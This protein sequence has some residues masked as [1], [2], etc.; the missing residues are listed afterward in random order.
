M[1][2]LLTDDEVVAISVRNGVAWPS[3]LPTIELSEDGLSRSERSGLR[4]LA[5]RGFLDVSQDSPTID[6]EVA[7][8]VL[9]A[10]KA[11][12]W[13]AAYVAA[14]DAPTVLAGDS[15]Y[16]YEAESESLLDAVS[17]AGVHQFTSTSADDARALFVALAKNVFTFGVRGD[18]TDA[19]LFIGG[20]ASDEWVR[21]CM[22]EVVVGTFTASAYSAESSSGVWT[23]SELQAVLN[24]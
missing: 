2:V 15:T 22:G 5:V 6:A 9:L 24:A 10:S 7:Q 14:I 4:S 12:R 13:T 17:A 3:P 16:L 11:A 18:S 1:T 20:N 21:V 19:A 8:T 23:G